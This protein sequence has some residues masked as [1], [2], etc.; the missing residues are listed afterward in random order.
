MRK[1]YVPGENRVDNATTPVEMVSPVDVSGA[2]STTQQPDS[3]ARNVEPAQT[4]SKAFSEADAPLKAANVLQVRQLADNYYADVYRYAYRLS[5][6]AAEA[7][8]LTQQTFLMALQRVH[9]LREPSRA[10][11][12]LFAVLRSCFL[13]GC[14]KRVPLSAGSLELDI[15][16]IPEEVSELEVDSEQLQ[17]ALN[18]LSEEFRLVLVM[19]YFEQL[20]YKEIASALEVA[21][22]TVMS[23]LARAK[24]Q[25]RYKLIST[26]G[27]SGQI[28]QRLSIGSKMSADTNTK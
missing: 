20:S 3:T 18:E 12:W 10:K 28:Q 1:R 5:G 21:K 9:Q 15:G 22:G 17:K 24:R 14:R 13:K 27:T 7:D 6:A 16:M 11:A 8:D 23:R 26:A 25:L 4:F 19:F 2:L